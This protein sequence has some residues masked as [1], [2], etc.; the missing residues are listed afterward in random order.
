MTFDTA[1]KHL[2]AEELAPYGFRKVKGKRPYFARMVGDEIVH[3]ITYRNSW[4]FR[5]YKSFELRWGVATVYR[6][7][8]DFDKNPRGT[9]SW[10]NNAPGHP[11]FQYREEIPMEQGKAYATDGNNVDMM[12]ELR[13]SVEVTKQEILPRLDQITTLIDCKKFLGG[14]A[15]YVCS[16]DSY[17][18][19]EKEGMLNFI[20]YDFN[21]FEADARRVIENWD[22]EDRGWERRIRIMNEQIEIFRKYAEDE[23]YHRR[24]EEELERR[25]IQ[26]QEILRSYG[27][28]F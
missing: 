17:E 8:I 28:E 25:K 22:R 19:E 23:T 21:E 15:D 2:Y 7:K 26:N 11:Y 24:V 12:E 13:N 4:D 6:G 10:T 9:T 14:V 1:F 3:V 16:L 27:L 18:A 5:P 20:L